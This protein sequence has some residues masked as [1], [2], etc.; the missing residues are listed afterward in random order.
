MYV[1]VLKSK[2]HNVTVTDAKLE[3]VGSITIDKDLMEAVG[4]VKNERVLVVNNRNGERIETYVIAGERKSGVI[5]LNG[6]AAHKFAKGDVAIIMSFT[7]IK[8][9]LAEDYEPRIIFPYALNKSWLE[10]SDIC[11][12]ILADLLGDNGEITESDI[13]SVALQMGRTEQEIRTI[14]EKTYK[15]K[16]N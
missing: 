3:Y 7:S 9:D 4:L 16:N 5:C 8:E 1:T 13:R 14:A 15:D 11:Y 2:L 6:A 12:N 10:N